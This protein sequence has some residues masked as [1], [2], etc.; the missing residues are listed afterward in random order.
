MSSRRLLTLIVL[1]LVATIAQPAVAEDDPLP[2][3]NDGTTKK[4]LVGFIARVTEEGR[5]DFV[6]IAERIA[7]FDNDGTLWPEQPMYFQLAFA[8]DRIKALADKHPEWRDQPPFKAVLAGDIT[9]ALAGGTRDR[10]E[11][12]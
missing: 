8:V 10:L 5:P 9:A 4:S 7:V 3:W 2:S 6:P 1:S 12:V 11:L